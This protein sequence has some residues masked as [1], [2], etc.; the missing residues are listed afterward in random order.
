MFY[1][2]YDNFLLYF[3]LFNIIWSPYQNYVSQINFYLVIDCWS[4]ESRKYILFSS[5][6]STTKSKVDSMAQIGTNHINQVN[7]SKNIKLESWEQ[8]WHYD[9]VSGLFSQLS[10]WA[11]TLIFHL[12]CTIVQ[13]KEHFID[14][15][16]AASVRHWG[17]QGQAG[18][19][20]R[21]HDCPC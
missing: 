17:G 18:E 4:F 13:N 5:Q 1:W 12:N 15:L 16:I 6:M 2:V 21:Q 14:W 20:G 11:R 9:L 8:T 3:K 7:N 19:G 10:A